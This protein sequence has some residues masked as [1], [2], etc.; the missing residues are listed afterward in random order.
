[1]SGFVS[2]WLRIPV[3]NYLPAI[4]TDITVR[5]TGI[6]I[7]MRLK[8]LSAI[9]TLTGIPMT[10][11]IHSQ[12]V[13]ILM[14]MSPGRPIDNGLFNGLLAAAVVLSCF[15]QNL[16]ANHTFLCLCGCGGS[17]GNML[18]VHQLLAAIGTNLPM[19]STVTDPL[20]SGNM[21]RD[22]HMSTDIAGIVTG[23]TVNMNMVILT[24]SAPA[25]FVPMSRL[26]L[27]PLR[28]EA[29][30]MSQ[31]RLDH[32]AAL[33]ANLRRFFGSLRT[34]CM[35]LIACLLA[36]DGTHMPMS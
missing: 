5:I 26:T 35:V 32:I 19:A 2:L 15:L 27:A 31:S 34:G 22:T 20:S 24:T 18:M 4:S 6:V 12:L 28:T 3:M 21:L 36:A 10:S 29:V 16:T 11:L 1:M 13:I 25:A 9:T 33:C 30:L 17:A 7:S 23:A 8:I 14:P